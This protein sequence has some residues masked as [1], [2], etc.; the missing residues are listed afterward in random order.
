MLSALHGSLSTSEMYRKSYSHY[1]VWINSP[2][3]HAHNSLTGVEV[4]VVVTVIVP[5]FLVSL[6][7]T[8][9][10]VASITVLLGAI[11]VVLGVLLVLLVIMDAAIGPLMIVVVVGLV[12]FAT[13]VI[14][15]VLIV[16]AEAVI[17]EATAMLGMVIV[18]VFETMVVLVE[19]TVFIVVVAPVNIIE[20]LKLSFTL[21]FS[22]VVEPMLPLTLA[23]VVVGVTTVV[24]ES[25]VPWAVMMVVWG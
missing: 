10:V 4:T 13:L 8:V 25:A 21:I 11:V 20:V 2:L 6:G 18:V 7:A 5:I 17:V 12:V 22:D 15:D 23:V 3:V 9:L 16:A 19:S 14:V 24:V 1:S